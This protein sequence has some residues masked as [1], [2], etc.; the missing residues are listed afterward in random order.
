[1]NPDVEADYSDFLRFPEGPSRLAAGC[2][3]FG[4]GM[5][6]PGPVG[7]LSL[8][9]KTL[10]KGWPL[11]RIDSVMR[12][13]L[14]AGAY[15][16]K[17]RAGVPARAAIKEYVDLAGAFFGAEEAGMVNAVLDALGHHYGA[18]EFAPRG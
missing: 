9:D 5:I 13:I 17:S 1:M 12:A 10:A 14:P 16:L 4:P 8:I 7:A 6:F 18:Q 11:A 3:Q 15:E 2:G